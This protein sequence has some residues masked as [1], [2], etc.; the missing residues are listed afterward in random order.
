M[1]KR[2]ALA[3]ADSLHTAAG[4][5]ERERIVAGRALLANNMDLKDQTIV[6]QGAENSRRPTVIQK[7]GEAYH[8]Y[9]SFIKYYGVLHLMD[10]LEEG[11]SLQDIMA[12]L[13]GRSRTNWEN[14]GGQLIESNALHT[15]LDDIKSKKIDSWDDIHEFYHDKSCLLY[16]S[17]SP[18]D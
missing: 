10:A 3:V 14:I 7:V 5:D 16:T 1:Y 18:R 15:F 4:K 11:M 9:R 12:S 8:L 17:P 6:L 2:Q 13:T